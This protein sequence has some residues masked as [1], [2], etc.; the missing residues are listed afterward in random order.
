M[1][2]LIEVLP[3]GPDGDL[4]QVSDGERFGLL[5]MD[6]RHAGWEATRGTILARPDLVVMLDQWLQRHGVLV[7]SALPARIFWSELCRGATR[8][9]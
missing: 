4:F 1:R 7:G 5:L 6:G 3:I 9:A 2:D 8:A